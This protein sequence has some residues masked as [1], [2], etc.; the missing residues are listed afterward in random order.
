MSA[1][2]K[3]LTGAPG[4]GKTYQAAEEAV[5]AVDGAA[6]PT[7]RAALIDRHTDL[8]TSGDIVWVTFH[9]SYSYEDFVEGFRPVTAP[10]GG[11]VL[12]EV[13]PGPFLQACERC[14]ADSPEA[15]FKALKVG[16]V[17]KSTGTSYTV[18]HADDSTVVM[19]SAVN[20]ADQI[21]PSK[22]AV[23]DWWTVKKLLD[24][25]ILPAQLSFPGKAAKDR[26]KVASAAGISVTDLASSGHLRAIVDHLTTGASM[27]PRRVAIVIDEL[28]RADLSRVFG[29][30]MTL[31]ELDKRQGAPEERSIVLPYSQ[32]ALTVPATLSVI[33]TMNTAD[34][35]LAEIDLAL[36]RR[37]EF[38]N[39]EPDPD[40]CPTNYGGINVTDW[41]R[42]RN[43]ALGALGFADNRIGHAELMPDKLEAR[44]NAGG[45]PSNTAG[46]RKALADT[47]RGKIL[48]IVL[49]IFRADWRQAE[50]V[51][52]GNGLLVNDPPPA[53]VEAAL[54]TWIMGDEAGNYRVADFWDPSHTAWDGA[55]FATAMSD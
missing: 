51:L 31:L 22:D 10:S 13:R 26:A 35:S 54:D 48:P 55:Q 24:A 36:R 16:D 21:A 33:A 2:M 44:R 49:D 47:I 14:T 37:F 20:R 3:I 6:A 4:T 12:Y 30:L 42:N 7:G 28:N 52:G 25:R 41:L 50:A 38:H 18:V 19:N 15:R 43:A 9:P 34:R 29:E 45:Y 32:A 23:A 40:L 53:T 8:V 46:K 39:I 1:V 5:K 27:V 11:G 17:L